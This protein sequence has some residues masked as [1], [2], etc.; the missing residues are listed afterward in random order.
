MSKG[1]FD[2]HDCENSIFPD[3]CTKPESIT[4]GLSL[5]LNYFSVLSQ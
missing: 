4:L 3:K 1:E 5:I 2:A